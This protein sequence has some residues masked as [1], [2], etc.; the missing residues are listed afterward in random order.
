MTRLNAEHVLSDMA[1]CWEVAAFAGSLK[2]LAAVSKGVEG[3]VRQLKPSFR[4][5]FLYILAGTPG[6][7]HQHTAGVRWQL[8]TETWEPLPP[9]GFDHGGLLS[10]NVEVVVMDGRLYVLAGAIKYG[11]K[12][13]NLQIFD[14]VSWDW[15]QVAS[16]PCGECEILLELRSC[17]YILGRSLSRN[18]SWC[19][20]LLRYDPRAAA[21]SSGQ[22][23]ELEVMPPVLTP[24]CYVGAAALDDSL[25]AVGGY[26]ASLPAVGAAEPL[27]VVERL[28]VASDS[29]GVDTWEACR[30][31]QYPRFLCKV[32]PVKGCLYVL[33][34]LNSR[35]V[36][37]ALERLNPKTG[38]WSSLAS[39]PMVK[40]AVDVA[41]NAGQILVFGGADSVPLQH[42]AE[43]YDPQTNRWTKLSSNDSND[44]CPTSTVAL[45]GPP[46]NLLAVFTESSINSLGTNLVIQH[47]HD[48][49]DG[50]PASWRVPAD[51]GRLRVVMSTEAE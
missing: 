21:T 35:G 34:G 38:D 2:V 42:T 6:G 46:D 22:K 8:G 37:T 43:R 47:Y 18:G 49:R 50:K 16:V 44:S 40:G 27:A 5:P 14:P 9:L 24:R 30:S 7:G 51:R 10:G 17:L 26:A 3:V 12:D 1:V 39:M 31:M 28:Q 23:L 13:C 4:T 36:E 41:E 25:Y 11:N 29:G 20:K 33:G 32:V 15:S 19:P 45:V 48:H